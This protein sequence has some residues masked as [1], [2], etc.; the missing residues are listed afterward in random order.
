[1]K[2]G[3]LFARTLIC[4]TA[5]GAMALLSVPAPAQYIPVVGSQN[6]VTA[7]PTVP[8]PRGSGPPPVP[9][10]GAPVTASR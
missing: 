7:D 4:V 1:M 3:G 10:A 9:G 6:T 2:L 8:R 5:L